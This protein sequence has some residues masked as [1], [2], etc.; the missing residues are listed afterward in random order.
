MNA[1]KQWFAGLQLRERIIITA[2]SVLVVLTAIYMLALAPFYNAVNERAERVARKEVDLAWMRSVAGEAAVLSANQPISAAPSGESLVVLVDRSAREC[3]L[4]SA[5]TGQTPTGD[6]GIRVRLEGADF[7]KLMVCLGTLQQ[8]HA[9][10]IESA[11]IDR[12]GQPGLVNASLV[13]TRA[14]G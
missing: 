10:N 2:G 12:T 11:T 8:A 6:A 5:L 1:L 7:D 13:L 4:A 9:V 14:G 3:G